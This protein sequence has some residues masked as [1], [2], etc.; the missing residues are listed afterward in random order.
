MTKIGDTIWR[1]EPERRRYDGKGLSARPIYREHFVPYTVVGETKISWLCQ[2]RDSSHWPTESK[3]KKASLRGGFSYWHTP[4]SMEANIW[5]EAN[6][7]RLHMDI[8]RCGSLPVLQAIDA[9][10]TGRVKP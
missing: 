5:I 4:E 10:L 6:R 3:V 8:L 9:L 7:A 2:P 1:F